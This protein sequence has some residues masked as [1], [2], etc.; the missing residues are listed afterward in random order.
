MLRT[1]R[2][3]YAAQPSVDPQ[4][5]RELATGVSSAQKPPNIGEFRACPHLTATAP[6]QCRRSVGQAS[7]RACPK[8]SR[9]CSRRQRVGDVLESL[10]L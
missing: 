6:Q 4:L 8:R 10:A 9:H 7:M 1:W 5:V 3:D 2:S